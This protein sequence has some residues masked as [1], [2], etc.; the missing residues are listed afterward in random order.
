MKFFILL[1]FF[2]FSICNSQNYKFEKKVNKDYLKSNDS[3]NTTLKFV[4]FSIIHHQS[5]ESLSFKEKY[6]VGFKFENDAIDP[7]SY[8]K[9]KENNIDISNMLNE[10]FG[11]Q[12]AKEL[13]YLI[14]GLKNDI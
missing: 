4:I 12:W 11:N 5:E 9:A 7:I 6:G 14:P 1:F 8:K 2:T 3:V 10:K 13:P